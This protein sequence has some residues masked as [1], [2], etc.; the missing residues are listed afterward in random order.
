M[1]CGHRIPL[2]KMNR[3]FISPCQMFLMDGN[4]EGRIGFRVLVIILIEAGIST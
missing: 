2:Q 4:C 3:R 1:L